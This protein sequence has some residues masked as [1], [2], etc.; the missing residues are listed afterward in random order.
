MSNHKSKKPVEQRIHVSQ[1]KSEEKQNANDALL[2]AKSQ[3][4]KVTYLLKN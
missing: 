1:W 2:V 4:K 3:N